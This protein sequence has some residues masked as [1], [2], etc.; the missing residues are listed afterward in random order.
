MGAEE[1]PHLISLGGGGWAAWRDV[2][3]RGAGFPAETVDLLIDPKLA[4]MADL[5]V[6]DAGRRPAYLEEYWAATTRLSSAVR[7]VARSARL[8]EAV[9]WQNPKLITLC[10]DKAAA[11]EP[12]NTRGRNHELTIA[13]YLQRYSMKND[14]IGFVGPVGWARWAEA[15]PPLAMHVGEH[16]LTRRTVYFETWAIDA[17]ARALSA[18]R[19]LRPWLVPRLF[20]AHQLIGAELHMP[21]RAPVALTTCERKMLALV[22][23]TRSVRDIAVEMARS[24]CGELGDPNALLAAFDALVIRGLVRLDL[25]GAIEAWPERTL[26]E[27]LGR[28]PDQRVRK[29]A[30]GPVWQL[31]AARDRV[32]ASA[33]DDVALGTALAELDDKFRAI[34]GMAGERRPGMTYAGRALV[35]E[36]TVRDTRVTL[37]PAIRED[38]ARP[39]GLLLDSARW[40]AAEIGQQYDRFFLGL[41]E[42]RAAQLGST[43]VPLAAILSLATP[44]LFYNPRRLSGVSQLAVAEFQRRWAT[45]LHI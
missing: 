39:L 42:R 5:A 16:F 11:G 24:E 43:A 7:E 21:G 30:A 1:K 18:D 31:I 25:L 9:A 22:D 10:L 38:L 8:R 2:V 20:S 23:G 17:V 40:L 6:H 35:Y 19:P 36:D 3:L 33:G 32:G 12:R 37:G 28:I 41:Y 45:I 29:R 13:S 34:T 44:Q 27:R 15:G 14:T 26:L 4:D